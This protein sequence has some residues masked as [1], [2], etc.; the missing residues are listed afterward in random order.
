[1]VGDFLSRRCWTS[2]IRGSVKG[3]AACLSILAIASFAHAAIRTN[4]ARET[5]SLTR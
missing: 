1:L 4:A 5:W 2:S 3:L